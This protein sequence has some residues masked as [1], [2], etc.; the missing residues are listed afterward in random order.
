MGTSLNWCPSFLFVSIDYVGGIYF[1]NDVT[2]EYNI[3]VITSVKQIPH[4]FLNRTAQVVSTNKRRW[5]KMRDSDYM[6]GYQKQALPLRGVPNWV[7]ERYP[8]VVSAA[9]KDGYIFAKDV[10]AILRDEGLTESAITQLLKILVDAGYLERVGPG[11]YRQIP[12]DEI[13]RAEAK[14]A[15]GDKGDKIIYDMLEFVRGSLD[16]NLT[17]A[18]LTLLYLRVADEKWRRSYRRR[19]EELKKNVGVMPEEKI[20]ELRRLA[21]ELAEPKIPI[22]LLAGNAEQGYSGPWDHIA[23]DPGKTIDRIIEVLRG[24]SENT[25][26]TAFKNALLSPINIFSTYRHDP[27]KRNV[28][29]HLVGYLSELDL[30]K[31]DEQSFAFMIGRAYEKILEYA[32]TDKAKGG[33]QYTPRSVVRLLVKIVD[34]QPMELIYDPAVGSAGMLIEAYEHVRKEHPGKEDSIVVYGQDNSDVAYPVAV[35]N[36]YLHGVKHFEVWKGDTLLNPHWP[37]GMDTWPKDAEIPYGP[38]DVVLA[39]PPWNVKKKYPDKVIKDAVH[40]YKI[41]FPFGLPPSSSA[42][43]LWIQHMITSAK[44]NGRIGIVIDNGALFRG[45]GKK[46]DR[47]KNIR[48]KVIEADLVDAVILLPEKKIFHNTGSQGVLLILNKDKPAERKGKILFINASG[49]EF[50]EVDPNARKKLYKLTDEAI[51]RIATAYHEYKEEEGFSRVVTL[52]EVRK[53][54]Y[55]LNVTLYVASKMEEDI[56]PVPE[57]LKEVEDIRKEKIAVEE[58]ALQYAREIAKVFGGEQ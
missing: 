55:N 19:L 3:T 56:T 57:A 1:G 16:Q 38:Y 13:I 27:E 41:R 20:V 32:F 45:S 44:Q 11:I 4:S 46:N 6:V 2:L 28:I 48:S 5:S 37:E 23:R 12:I 53:N 39:N 15:E 34:P 47:E 9:N 26:N 14:M 58:E 17:I 36:L 49:D 10:R 29:T 42:D 22:S 30:S 24:I 18:L 40:N 35:L 51:E 54:D 52:D 33:E 31:K 25:D 8:L 50:A 7:A 43:W 21:A